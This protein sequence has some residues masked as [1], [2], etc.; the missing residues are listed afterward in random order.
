[1][2]EY[3]LQRGDVRLENGDILTHTQTH[4]HMNTHTHT[5]RPIRWHMSFI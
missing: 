3:C 5:H 2:K 4:T 1:M